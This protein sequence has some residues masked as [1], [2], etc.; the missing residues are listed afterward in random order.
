MIEHLPIPGDRWC[1]QTTK[2]EGGKTSTKKHK[3][4][5]C[6]VRMKRNEWPNVGGIST[7]SI[8]TVAPSLKESQVNGH[9]A[10][11]RNK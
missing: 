11:A 8:G 6:T 2:Q 7:R 3:N 9:M 5:V 4:Y 10:K 1:P